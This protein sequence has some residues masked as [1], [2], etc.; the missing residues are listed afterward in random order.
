MRISL[1]NTLIDL[2]DTK[3]LD[4][5][6]MSFNHTELH[7]LVEFPLSTIKTTLRR[8]SERMNCVSKSRSGCPQGLTEEQCE[9]CDHIYD[10]TMTDPHIK[11]RDMLEE[12]NYA[13]KVVN[14]QSA[15]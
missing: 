13:V 6:E 11:T 8:E 12:V 2:A 5:A 15:K 4:T 14:S 9:L 10:L 7:Y 3:M 1:L